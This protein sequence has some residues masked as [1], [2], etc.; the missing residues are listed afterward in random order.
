MRRLKEVMLLLIANDVPLS[1][2]LLEYPLELTLTFP[3]G[4]NGR[5]V[6]IRNNFQICFFS[7]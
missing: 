5:N 4:C 2:E 1:T 3:T 7:W 6:D